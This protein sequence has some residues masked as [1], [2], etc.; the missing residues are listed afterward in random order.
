VFRYA[1]V[2][3]C[4]RALGLEP[5]LFQCDADGGESH[6]L[7]LSAFY[8][9]S[10]GLCIHLQFSVGGNQHRNVALCVP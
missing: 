9:S 7:L 2:Q 4:T 3:H 8:Y 5:E 1:G 10:L 6:P